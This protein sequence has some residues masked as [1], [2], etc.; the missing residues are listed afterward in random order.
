[1]VETIMPTKTV[2]NMIAL[3]PVPN[4]M[5]MRGPSAIF[6]RAFSTT[7]YGS[8]TLH[9][10]SLHQSASAMTTPKPTAIAKPTRVSAKVTPIW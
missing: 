2:M 10:V 5:M 7:M 4:Q 1:M 6:G 9:S 8:K 3:L